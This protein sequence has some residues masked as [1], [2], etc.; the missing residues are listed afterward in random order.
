MHTHAYDAG[1]FGYFGLQE[2]KQTAT[3]KGGGRERIFLFYKVSFKLDFKKSE[4]SDYAAV[5]A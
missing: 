1:I 4:W 3:G 5:Q 2:G